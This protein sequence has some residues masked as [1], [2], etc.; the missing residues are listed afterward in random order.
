MYIRNLLSTYLWSLSYIYVC[1][2][3][4][5]I[6]SWCKESIERIKEL[7]NG[8][9]SK[10]RQEKF[11]K[12]LWEIFLVIG[13]YCFNSNSKVVASATKN[14]HNSIT[15]S[16]MKLILQNPP[17]NSCFSTPGCKPTAATYGNDGSFR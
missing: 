6:A 1:Q 16:I 9:L 11:L 10:S 7:P 14:N 17:L 5:R 15:M 13:A 3:Q 12:L 8:I 4:R 2:N